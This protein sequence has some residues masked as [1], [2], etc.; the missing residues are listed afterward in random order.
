MARPKTATLFTDKHE[1]H[2]LKRGETRNTY[3]RVLRV[4]PKKLL[5][6]A[7]IFD[8]VVP[9][10][11]FIPV[12]LVGILCIITKGREIMIDRGD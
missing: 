8:T 7:I 6:K 12:I 3:G 11:F 9:L 4:L 5:K 10:T 1:Q 2:I